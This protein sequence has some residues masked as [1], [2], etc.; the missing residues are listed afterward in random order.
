MR[1]LLTVVGLAVA[2]VAGCPV[3]SQAAKAD[4]DAKKV[5]VATEAVEKTG[6]LEVI[7]A[8]K[9]KKEKYNTVLLKVGADTFKLLPG[10]NKNVLKML[11]EM[12]G[13]EVTVKGDMMPANPPKYPMAAIKVSEYTEKVVTPAAA[14]PVAEPAAATP[15]PAAEPAPAAAPA[16]AADAAPAA[17]APADGK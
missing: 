1:K 13:K 6:V 9:T 4:K 14:A 11:E 7:P 16:P 12:T 2:L 8:D 10:K 3:V 5:I 17:P 15:A